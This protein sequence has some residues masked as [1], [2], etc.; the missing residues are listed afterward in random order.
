[1]K[2]MILS[3]SAINNYS[4]PQTTPSSRNYCRVIQLRL[5]A[6][7]TEKDTEFPI[8]HHHYLHTQR[9]MTCLMQIDY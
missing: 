5:V 7:K 4:L 3:E 9:T 6:N 8:S 1:M 2:T